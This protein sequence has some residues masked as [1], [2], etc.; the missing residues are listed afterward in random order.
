[1][2]KRKRE[3]GATGANET[4]ELSAVSG[5]PVGLKKN[6]G[7]GT[8]KIGKSESEGQKTGAKEQELNK[9]R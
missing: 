4:E 7:G 2:N 6:R 8:R 1:M 9:E 3:K 5:D